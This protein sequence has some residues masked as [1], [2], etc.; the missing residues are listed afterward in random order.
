MGFAGSRLIVTI[1]F[2]DDSCTAKA[3][4]TLL[5]KGCLFKSQM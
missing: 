2:S 5:G 4:K 1:V 3:L